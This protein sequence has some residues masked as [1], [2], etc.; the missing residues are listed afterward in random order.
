MSSFSA[1]SMVGVL[2]QKTINAISF[3]LGFHGVS[4]NSSIHT[5]LSLFLHLLHL[6][7]SQNWATPNAT[8]GEGVVIRGGRCTSHRKQRRYRMGPPATVQDGTFG[9]IKFSWKKWNTLQHVQ[10][11]TYKSY[12]TTQ[13]QKKS[14]QQDKGRNTTNTQPALETRFGTS[15]EPTSSLSG[16]WRAETMKGKQL[17][18]VCVCVCVSDLHVYTYIHRYRYIYIQ[19]IYHVISYILQRFMLYFYIGKLPSFTKPTFCILEESPFV[20]WCI[21]F[22]LVPGIV[23]GVKKKPPIGIN[24]NIASYRVTTY[25]GVESKIV[26]MVPQ[27]GWCIKNGK[28]YEKFM[29]WGVFPLF[30]ETPSC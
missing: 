27:N 26:G 10:H 22:P 2:R 25:L 11:N 19:Y 29:I 6:F 18:C 28:P 13:D 17:V 30:L 4:R 14:T 1:V 16:S 5:L 9:G 23:A 7:E 24:V 12:N 3:L 20:R 8:P 15:K 21:T